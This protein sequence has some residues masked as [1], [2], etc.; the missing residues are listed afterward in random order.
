MTLS[1]PERRWPSR[2]G[3]VP[4]KITEANTYKEANS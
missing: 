1:R 3:G 4:H 2:A